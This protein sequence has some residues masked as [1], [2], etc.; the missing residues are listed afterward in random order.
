MRRGVLSLDLALPQEALKL[1]IEFSSAIRAYDTNLDALMGN[2][3]V[4][5]DLQPS[6]GVT[7]LPEKTDELLPGKIV[8]AWHDRLP[9]S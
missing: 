2:A 6:C 5:N 8:N 1:A 7:L 3:F 9:C 4:D